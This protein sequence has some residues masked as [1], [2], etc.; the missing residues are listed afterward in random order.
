MMRWEA[1][2]NGRS[3]TAR[4]RS[5]KRVATSLASAPGGGARWAIRLVMSLIYGLEKPRWAGRYAVPRRSLS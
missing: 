5:L 1:T 4:S 2:C 3:A